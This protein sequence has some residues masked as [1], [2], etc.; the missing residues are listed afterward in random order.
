MS[1]YNFSWQSKDCKCCKRLILIFAQALC[2]NSEWN[3][4]IHVFYKIN[5]K[6]LV[7]LGGGSSDTSVVS[8]VKDVID[9]VKRKSSKAR[10]TGEKATRGYGYSSRWKKQKL[11]DL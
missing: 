3:F 7:V 10:T 9:A 1:T 5:I 4:Y 11:K 2:Y 8:R 6:N